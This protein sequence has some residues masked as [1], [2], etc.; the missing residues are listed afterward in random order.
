M[1]VPS[2]HG[3]IKQPTLLL[4]VHHIDEVIS[5][6]LAFC[7]MSSRND[8]NFLHPNIKT[9]TDNNIQVRFANETANAAYIVTNYITRRLVN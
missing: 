2:M 5:F 1:F 3:S 8:G 4:H 7:V 6:R 9:N